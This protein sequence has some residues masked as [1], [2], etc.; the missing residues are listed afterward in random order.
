MKGLFIAFEGANGVGK[1][2]IIK[3]VY[4]K[5]KN[6][7]KDVYLTKEPS[8]SEIGMF[9]RT[10]MEK[11]S[12][13]ANACLVAADRY[14]H[15][16]TDIMPKVEKG[17]IVLCDRNILSAFAYNK[18]DGVDF[19]YTDNLYNTLTYPDAIIVFTASYETIQSRL[20]ER[21]ELLRYEKEE[22]GK[23]LDCLNQAIEYIKQHKN[24]KFFEVST[25]TT[26]EE[27]V[28]ETY[29]IIEMFLH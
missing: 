10:M 14:N 25:E 26:I 1:S 24:V 20:G 9:A 6:Q 13:K 8:T 2:T 7:D 11:I 17:T 27:T 12:D 28:K 16:E 19:E 15:V 5:L 4:D 3:H 29:K 21:S 18:I 23:E 22:K